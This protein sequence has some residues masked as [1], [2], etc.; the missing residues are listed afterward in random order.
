M[1]L[2]KYFKQ[3]STKNTRPK[4]NKNV[5]PFVNIGGKIFVF[6]ELDSQPIILKILIKPHNSG[7]I[8]ATKFI[9]KLPPVDYNKTFENIQ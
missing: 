9:D 6:L 8:Y 2:S 3:S 4:N 7:I 5:L 1:T